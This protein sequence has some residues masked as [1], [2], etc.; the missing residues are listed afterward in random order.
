MSDIRITVEKIEAIEPHPDADRLEIAKVLGTQVVVPRGQYHA[1][2]LVAYFPPDIMLPAKFSEALGVQKYLKTSLFNGERIPC[3]VAAC[4][5]RGVPSYGFMAET[6]YALGDDLTDVYGAQKYEAPDRPYRGRG[7][8]TGEVWGGLDR[9]PINFQKYTDIQ[10]YW[11]YH[12]CIPEGMLVRVCEKIHGCVTSQTRIR[13]ADGRSKHIRDIQPGESV[14]GVDKQGNLVPTKVIKVFQNGP[15]ADWL[16]IKY[17]RNTCGHG[18][19]V[20]TITCTPNHRFLINKKYIKA[21]N[22]AVGSQVTVLRS[23]WI[24][25]HTQ[26]QIILGKLLGDGSLS[27][28]KVSARLDWGHTNKALT[29]WTARGLGNL[30]AGRRVTQISGYGSLMYRAGTHNSVFILNKFES[31]VYRGKKIVPEWVSE[32]LTPLAIAFWYMDDGSLGHHS[33][34]N[35]RAHF[36][37]CGFTKKDCSVLIRGLRRFGIHAIYYVADGYS[38]LRLNTDDAERLFA[39]IAPYIPVELQ[40]KLPE[41][42]RGHSGWLPQPLGSKKTDLVLCEIESIEHITKSQQ[43]WDLETETHNYLPSSIVTHNSNSRA[44]LLKVDDEWRFFGGSHKT[45]RKKIDPEGRESVYWKPLEQ[46]GVLSLLTDLCGEKNDVIIYGE[47]FGPGVQDMDYGV[48][49]GDIGWRCYDICVNGTFLDWPDLVVNCLSHGIQLV[50]ILYVGP[51]SAG[52][53]EEWT[54]GPTK[55]TPNCKFKGREGVVITPLV[56]TTVHNLGRLILKSVS[57]DYKYRKN[58][59]DEGEL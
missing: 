43:R 29:E 28:T 2:Q 31:F 45:T 48:V 37:V 22:L 35:D 44:A 55:F 56:E 26:E 49:P 4:R 8:G 30:S 16:K 34:Q 32:E 46:Y 12:K 7:G 40:Y 14:V 58:S 20:G 41:R 25:S 6:T 36:A 50:P 9:E 13:M 24:L 38:R 27:T 23:D 15:T 51:F 42:Y 17:S 39:L 33:A 21:E 47:L 59:K 53:V 52:M 54:N 10:N 18:N 57:A 1:C 5:L 3:K 11:K 19:S